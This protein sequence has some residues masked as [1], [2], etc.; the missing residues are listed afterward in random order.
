[1]LIAHLSDLHLGFTP[2]RDAMIAQRLGELREIAPHHLVI[3]GDLSQA[4][5]SEQFTAVRELLRQNCFYDP[6]RLTLIP[7]NHDLFTFFFKDF[8]AGSDLYAKWH[9]LPRT[10]RQL[11]RYGW[12]EYEADLARFHTAFS[13]AFQGIITLNESGSISY[14]FIRILDGRTALIA[15]ESNRLLP[16]IRANAACSNGLVDLA[17]AERILV[18]PALENRRKIVLLHH[19]LLPEQLVAARMG[20]LYASMTRIRNREE[21]IGLLNRSGVDLV[22]H[23]HYHHHEEYHIGE[24]IPVLNSGEIEHWHLID[25][26]EEGVRITS[27][28]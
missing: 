12:Q 6:A 14:P 8:H 15:L 1:M 20:K 25:S 3:T 9:R 2:D 11:Y 16:Q 7:G 22:L 24:G 18:H 28:E 27:R 26:D 23:G 4:G 5:R 21:F 19:P 10:A 13:E 17:S